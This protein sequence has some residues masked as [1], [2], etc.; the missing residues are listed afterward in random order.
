MIQNCRC[1]APCTVCVQAEE[2]AAKGGDLG[3]AVVAGAVL[4]TYAGIVGVLAFDHMCPE[5]HARFSDGI[6]Q[7]KAALAE[8]GKRL[9]VA[10]V[11]ALH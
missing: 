8:R 2:V 9:S 1:G 7:L 5:H 3:A 6:E 4:G 11:G 10:P